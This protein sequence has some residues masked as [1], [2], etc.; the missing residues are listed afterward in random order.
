MRNSSTELHEH[1]IL[2]P[3]DEFKEELIIVIKKSR[4]I[5]DQRSKVKEEKKRKKLTCSSSRDNRIMR[6]FRFETERRT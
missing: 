3:R 6:S 2:K 5:S 1:F 4:R